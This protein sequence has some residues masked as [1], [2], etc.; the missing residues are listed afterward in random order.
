[1]D[2]NQY[3]VSMATHDLKCCHAIGRNRSYYLMP[4]I[5]LGRVKSGKHKC[6][7]FG[8]RYWKN[9]YHIKRVRYVFGWQLQKKKGDGDVN[10]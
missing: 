7:V 1:M 2:L 3:D 4:C 9:S 8:D 10:N 5:D 6:V